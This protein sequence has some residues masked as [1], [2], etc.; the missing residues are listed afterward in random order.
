MCV[1]FGQLIILW[2]LRARVKMKKKGSKKI[3]SEFKGG[4]YT[5][6]GFT[7]GSPKFA[8]FRMNPNREYFSRQTFFGFYRIYA[9]TEKPSNSVVSVTRN[10]HNI[11][12]KECLGTNFVETYLE[13]A[14][15][16]L[17]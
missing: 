4:I 8:A 5:G 2:R 16:C 9:K 15:F 14:V 7:T 12:E 17:S 3:V 10:S 6:R 1:L 11:Q 13:S